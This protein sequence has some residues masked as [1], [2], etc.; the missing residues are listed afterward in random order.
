MAPRHAALSCR[1]CLL[2]FYFRD[3]I[4]FAADGVLPRTLMPL[5]SFTPP[6]RHAVLLTLFAACRIYE[7][8]VDA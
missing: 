4:L 7:I 3:D 6:L 8:L 1:R 2:L 5:R